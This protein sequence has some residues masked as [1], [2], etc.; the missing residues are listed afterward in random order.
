MKRFDEKNPIALLM[1][2]AAVIIPI[3]FENSLLMLTI[4]LFEGEIYS[5]T[6]KKKMNVNGIVAALLMTVVCVLINCAAVSDGGEILFY[7]NKK[8]ITVSEIKGGVRIALLLL[9]MLVWFDCFTGIFTTEKI[10]MLF[11]HMPKVGMVFALT[12]KLIPEYVR[13]IGEVHEINGL[14][15]KKGAGNA[16]MATATYAIYGAASQADYLEYKG[17]DRIKRLPVKMKFTC[18]DGLLIFLAS[19]AVTIR[20]TGILAYYYLQGALGLVPVVYLIVENL[21]WKIY[22]KKAK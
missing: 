19:A 2:F 14:S 16:L 11:K 17:M 22:S 10:W 9:N 8:A 5:L 15:G 1:F 4:M 20:I 18:G 21:K 12:L 3:M 7:I 13:R 6:I